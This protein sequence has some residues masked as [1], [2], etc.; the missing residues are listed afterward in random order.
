MK[1]HNL[2]GSTFTVL[3]FV[4]MS[5]CGG[6]VDTVE[7]ATTPSTYSIGGTVRGLAA[8]QNIVLGDN[9]GDVLTITAN[10]SYAFSGRVAL[11]GNYVITITSQPIGQTCS[12]SHYSGSGVTGDVAS[13]DVTCSADTYAVAGAVTGLAAGQNVALT[14]NGTDALI[15]DADGTFSFATPVPYNGSYAVTVGTQPVGQTCTVSKGAGAGVTANVADVSVACS[16]NTYIISGMVSGLSVGAQVTLNNNSADAKTLGADGSFSFATPVAYNGSYAVTVGTQPVGQTCTVSLGSGT[17]VVATVLTV[18]VT[19]SVNTFTISGTVTGL[20]AGNQVTL[21][22]N[23]ADATVV[24][25]DGS[26]SFKTPV[27]FNGGYAVTVGT[28]PTAQ[29]CNVLNDSSAAVLS[30]VT[31]VK[32]SCWIR[33]LYVYVV[34]ASN[35]SILQFTIGSDGSLQPM[36]PPSISTEP[37]E[38]PDY[39][40]LD[41]SGHYLDVMAYDEDFSYVSVRYQIGAT[42]QLTL[43]GPEGGTNASGFVNFF[44]GQYFS[45]QF[46]TGNGISQF[47]VGPNGALTPMVPPVVGSNLA[48]L[49]VDS[50][51]HYLYARASSSIWQYSIQA[52]GSLKSMNPPNVAAAVNLTAMVI[53]PGH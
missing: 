33:P 30:D 7:P 1:L 47:T 45:Y 51:V 17:G 9:A 29:A 8:G 41:P 22:N 48:G 28:N 52:D 49:V 26:F 13:V 27:A 3:S 2:L 6:R 25:A 4:H 38:Q 43:V 31:N 37:F 24:Q 53:V 39:A 15:V 14:N 35:Y 36:I 46:L 42:G 19:C 23:G 21:S 20:K 44:K 18:G 32:V 5:G 16:A 40:A 11:N 12:V 34:D 10:G 50:T